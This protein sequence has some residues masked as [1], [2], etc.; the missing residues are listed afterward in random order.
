MYETGRGSFSIETSGT[1]VF[2]ELEMIVG[3]GNGAGSVQILCWS[4]YLAGSLVS[5]GDLNV[6]GI[7][8]GWYGWSDTGG[9]DRLTF[10]LSGGAPALRQGPYATIE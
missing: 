1:D 8:P 5:S 7:L 10:S 9:F 2:R 3:T 6:T 4:T